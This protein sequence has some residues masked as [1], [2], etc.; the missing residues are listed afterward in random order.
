MNIKQQYYSTLR[1]LQETMVFTGLL[2]QIAEIKQWKM[3]SVFTH[4]TPTHKNS[5]YW[6]EKTILKTD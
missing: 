3:D 5:W 6:S 2:C 4:Y 1:V